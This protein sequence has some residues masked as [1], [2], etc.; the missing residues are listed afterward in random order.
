MN[1]VSRVPDSFWSVY[2]PIIF[3]IGVVVLEN[4]TNVGCITACEDGPLE[5]LQ[6]LT[7]FVAFGLGIATLRLSKGICPPWARAFFLIG[8]IGALYIA[9]E[10]ISYGQRIFGWNTPLDWGLVNDQNETN[11]HNASSWFDQKPRAL[12]ELVVLI[13]GLL[14]PALHRWKPAL[15]PQQFSIVYPSHKLVTIAAIAIGI[16][17]YDIITNVVG[18]QDLFFIDRGSELQEICLFWFLLLYFFYKRRAL[19]SKEYAR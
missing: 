8:T 18:R 15:V 19:I 4:F 2:L 6:A 7:A 13:G 9:L 12:F 16:H 10:E 14:L 11:L 17:L 5:G 3:C 1:P